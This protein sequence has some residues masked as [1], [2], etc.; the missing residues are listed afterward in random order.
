MIRNDF[1]VKEN[2]KLLTEGKLEIDPKL[3]E[4]LASSNRKEL[5]LSS[6]QV[7]KYIV[8]QRSRVDI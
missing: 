4:H 7:H 2:W 6:G 1:E 3:Q 5:G 8:V